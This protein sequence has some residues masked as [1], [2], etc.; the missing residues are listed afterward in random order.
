MGDP[1]NDFLYPALADGQAEDGQEIVLHSAAA[2]PMDTAKLSDVCR[3]SGAEA[4]PFF[5]RNQSFDHPSASRATASVENDVLH[6]E[7]WLG[8]LEVLMDVLLRAHNI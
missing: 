1:V 7:P 3:K 2:V 6:I 8:T 4:A 5:W